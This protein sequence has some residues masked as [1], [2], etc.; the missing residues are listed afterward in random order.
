M[1]LTQASVAQVTSCRVITCEW[2]VAPFWL[3]TG[4]LK[5]DPKLAAKSAV[6]P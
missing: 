2:H 3:L 1:A 4:G 5:L 6:T